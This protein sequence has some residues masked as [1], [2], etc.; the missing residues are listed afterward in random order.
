MRIHSSDYLRGSSSDSVMVRGLDLWQKVV[1]SNLV[2]IWRN[3]VKGVKWAF[4]CS[5][6][7]QA[8]CCTVEPKPNTV[9]GFRYQ[10]RYINVDQQIMKPGKFNKLEIFQMT[11]MYPSMSIPISD[12][13]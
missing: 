4:D 3:N 8:N 13:Q 1:G 9:N 10:A 7:E 2:G 6:N 12:L 5:K 11:L